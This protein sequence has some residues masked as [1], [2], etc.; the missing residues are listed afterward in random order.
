VTALAGLACAAVGIGLAFRPFTSLSVLVLVVGIAMV[1]T[2]VGKLTDEAADGRTGYGWL[3]GA[4]WIVGGLV[5]LG[6]PDLTI[7]GI[8]LIAGVSMILGGVLDVLS[9]VRGSTDERVAAIIWGVASA[10]FGLLALG[11]PDVT[12]LV[13]AVVFGI[14]TAVFGARLVLA[15][16]RRR[17]GEASGT[18]AGTPRE[19]GLIRRWARVAAV[20]ALLL[21]AF[22]LAGVSSR[23]NRA[24][25]DVDPF[26]T[27]PDEVPDEPGRLLRHEEVTK[28]VPD[29]ATG[30]RILYTTTRDEG[31]PAVASA[32]VVV[33]DA[34]GGPVPVIAWAHGT[35]GIARR[36][37]PTI[38][39]SGLAAGAFHLT[40]Q[41]LDEGWALVATDY[42]GLGT[43][44]PH[45]YL[46]GQGEGRSVLDAVR[47]ARLIDDAD[48]S[49]QTVVWGHSQGGHAA[50]WTGAIA[51]AY[52]ADVPL[53]GVA[54]IAPA[55]DPIGLLDHLPG[56]TGGSIFATYVVDAYADVYADVRRSDYVRPAARTSF[57]A[58]AR[59]CLDATVLASVL[60]SV[61]IGFRGFV[62]DLSDGALAAR[63]EENVPDTPIEAPLLIGQGAADRLILP[64][65][66]QR[67]VDRLCERGQPVDHRT[68]AGRDHVAVMEADS[69]LVP[70]LIRWS[71]DRF[72]GDEP[73]PDCHA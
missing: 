49:D 17:R 21:V 27:A 72:A 7:R 4:A 5:A 66:Q 69:P 60:S 61:A 28:D 20:S 34:A 26:Y 2:G 25:G 19:K 57:E 22:G 73:T 6:R 1:A 15:A 48:L 63:L 50:L 40:D 9:G 24:T 45:P 56:V 53:S 54:A 71:H 68:Y 39:P 65:L 3:A 47:A 38:M 52:A 58:T 46:I 42:V 31:E 16:L 64:A 8:A 10:V 62:D 32:L 70:E 59:R 14:R 11:W 36:C 51:P 12:L 67:F 18:S 33:P 13:V 30:W 44:S 37:A 43:E 41:V 29:G 55:S 35:T 23:L